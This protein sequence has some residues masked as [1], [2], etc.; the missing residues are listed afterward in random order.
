[1]DRG[2]T[3]AHRSRRSHRRLIMLLLALTL[4]AT[5]GAAAPQA[6]AGRRDPP[7]P[8]LTRI[9]LRVSP[10]PLR[11]NQ[12]VRLAG[13]AYP[14]EHVGDFVT[15]V[16]QKKTG[17]RWRTVASTTF[18]VTFDAPASWSGSWN[19]QQN[20]TYQGVAGRKGTLA[21]WKGDV[22]YEHANV[23]LTEHYVEYEMT[24]ARGASSYSWKLWGDGVGLLQ[25][26]DFVGN[27]STENTGTLKWY[28][29][30]SPDGIGIDAYEGDSRH[31]SSGVLTNNVMNDPVLVTTKTVGSTDVDAMGSAPRHV[32]RLDGHMKATA[33][34][35]PGTMIGSVNETVTM[36]SSWDLAPSE[37]VDEPL[38]LRHGDYVG[39]MRFAQA[40]DYR[41][42]S[43][44]GGA[45]SP[46]V[47]LRVR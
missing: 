24:G 9:T 15:G 32:V 12:V 46:W 36:V 14:V 10:G 13:E 25:W 40:G 3:S 31:V 37:A 19:T 34:E 26:D 28:F 6:R 2:A 23:N 7:L 22:T 38:L 1:M 45:H 43:E 21:V 16:L 18:Q 39:R 20:V 17:S 30:E 44:V 33:L 8:A 41:L 47:T 5:L 11:P 4:G 35:R 29:A 42:R 27:R